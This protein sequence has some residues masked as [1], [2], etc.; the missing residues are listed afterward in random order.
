MRT[1]SLFTDEPPAK[2]PSTMQ[3]V[4]QL[5]DAD[6][7]FEWYPTTRRMVE[8]VSRNI[9]KDYGAIMDIGAGDGRV[10]AMLAEKCT[11][12]TLYAIEKS[13]IL[14]QQQPEAV[15]PVGTEFFEQDLMSLPVD[16]IFC[17]PPYSQFGAWASRIIETAHAHKVFLVL[18]QRWKESAE[19]KAALKARGATARTIHEDNFLDAE[20]C[21]RGVVH[22][23]RIDLG[24]QETRHYRREPEDPFDRE[25]GD[26]GVLGRRVHRRP[27]GRRRA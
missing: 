6:E 8:V 9:D 7:D 4:E 3:V 27:E 2:P 23:V 11:H 1:A 18:P 26:D 13:P 22:I 20:R 12:A 19:I 16:V 24:D 15:V 17:N 5:R 14:L 10:L 25:R 21:A